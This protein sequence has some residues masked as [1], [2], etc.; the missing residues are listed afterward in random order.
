MQYGRCHFRHKV[1]VVGQLQSP[2]AFNPEEWAS[3]G[4]WLVRWLKI[5]LSGKINSTGFPF[6]SLVMSVLKPVC[7]VLFF[8]IKVSF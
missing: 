8:G 2:A 7:V 3:G 5:E 1:D 4:N 6:S